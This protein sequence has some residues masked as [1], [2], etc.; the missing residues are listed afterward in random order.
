[1]KR[2][3]LRYSDGAWHNVDTPT[4]AAEDTK[5]TGE[6]LAIPIPHGIPTPQLEATVSPDERESAQT[7]REPGSSNGTRD[8]G[9]EDANHLGHP[10][11]EVSPAAAD[12]R[13]S[14]QRTI[15][16]GDVALQ[17]Q[18]CSDNVRFGSGS[19]S[20]RGESSGISFGGMGNGGATKAPQLSPEIYA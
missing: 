9:D 17:S 14:S 4:S 10:S 13:S 1:M 7:A 6:A 18:L 2:P 3:S 8:G 12:D 20:G 19:G 5:T 16:V 11:Q 15:Y